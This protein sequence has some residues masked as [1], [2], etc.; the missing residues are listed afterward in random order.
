[1]RLILAVATLA[2]GA[3]IPIGSV[4]AETWPAKPLRAIIPFAA[5]SITDI[6]PRIVLEKLSAQIGQPIIVDN[7]P[8]GAQTIG[9]NAVAKAEPDGY[10]FLVN[11]SAHVI[12]PALNPNL[13]YDPTRD[14][15]AVIPLGVVPSVLVVSPAKGFKK[16]SEFVAAAK[17]RPGAMNFASA[18]VGTATHL[19]AMQFQASAGIEA[20]HIPFKGGSEAITEVIAGRVDFFLAPIGVALPHVKDGRLAA[21]VVNSTNRSGALPE[22]PTTA[23]VGLKNAEYPFWIGV[24]VPAK[25]SREIVAALHRE[26]LKALQDAT[27]RAKLAELGV[28]QII[29]TPEE[30]DAR[31]RSEIATNAALVEAIGLKGQ[32]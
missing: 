5:G 18:G 3:G 32:Q 31:I 4:N 27:V 15:A 21:L 26:T 20:V 11:S 23:E 25:T 12:A 19:G 9:A 28:D 1:M 10:T 22:V 2:L 16:V 13:G 24:F 14:F 29:L 30:F 7:R 8:G 6:V 17:A